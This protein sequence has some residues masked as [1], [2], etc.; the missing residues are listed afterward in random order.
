MNDSGRVQS[1]GR[2]AEETFHP[3]ALESWSAKLLPTRKYYANYE[4]LPPTIGWPES[5]GPSAKVSP[6]GSSSGPACLVWRV[7]HDRMCYPQ[8]PRWP[9]APCVCVCVSVDK[10]TS[11][12]YVQSIMD[13]WPPVPGSPKKKRAA[14]P[15]TA[16]N[17]RIEI[18]NR[19]GMLPDLA[20]KTNSR[21]R[22]HRSRLSA[23]DRS[24]A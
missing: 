3:G 23:L 2:E 15:P 11:C 22:M 24:C 8:Q 13:V 7:L 10:V 12:V 9:A 17:F 14:D 1:F 16:L 21:S 6:S 20:A 18:R 19:S 5:G 4:G